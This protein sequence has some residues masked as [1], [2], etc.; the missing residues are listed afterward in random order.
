MKIHYL[1]AFSFV[2]CFLHASNVFVDP[3][4]EDTYLQNEQSRGLQ[5]EEDKNLQHER[6]RDIQFYSDMNLQ[7]EQT[8]DLQFEED[9][10]LQQERSLNR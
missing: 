4:R 1:L 2:S 10:F 7:R 6:T 5:I 9:K 8:R 3:Q